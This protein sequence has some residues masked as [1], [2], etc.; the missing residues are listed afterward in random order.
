VFGSVRGDIVATGDVTAA[1]LVLRDSEV[2]VG[3]QL[4]RV[5]EEIA[6]LQ[7]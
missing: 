1:S 6:A 7:A 3:V 4:I 2:D 5:Q